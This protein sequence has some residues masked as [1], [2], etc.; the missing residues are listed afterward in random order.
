M[1]GSKAELCSASLL[2][3]LFPNYFK[4]YLKIQELYE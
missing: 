3:K 4:Q 2:L 1:K